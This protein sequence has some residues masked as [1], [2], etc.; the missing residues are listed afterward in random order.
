MTLKSG[1]WSVEAGPATKPLIALIHGAMDRSSG[2]LKLS[3]R[4]DEEFRVLRY[5]RRGY[6]RSAAHRGP[7][8]MG[9]Q[10]ED[11]VALLGGR[12]A[13]LFG[14]SYGGNVALAT[15]ARHRDLVEGVA[16]YESP[17]PWEQWWPK[18]PPGPANQS[19]AD[20]AEAFMRRLIGDQRWAALPDATRASR[21]AEGDAL[22]GELADL[23][24]HRPWL[25]ADVHVPVVVG[26]GSLADERYQKGMANVASS[27]AGA[28]LVRVEG[29]GHTAPSVMP[30]QFRRDVID[31][32]L[33]RLQHPPAPNGAGVFK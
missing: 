16:I 31:P 22:R 28:Q 29:G 9:A 25:G 30:D 1:I 27:I 24:A 20:A 15:A 23:G 13:I 10:V 3:R 21:R 5:D 17:L 12:R 2:M 19:S 8:T 26:C 18:R 11:L 14:H 6:G 7:F 33:A 4:L 32:L